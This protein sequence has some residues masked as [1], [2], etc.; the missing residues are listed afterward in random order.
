MQFFLH[1]TALFS[2]RAF[3][4]SAAR[5]WL[6]FFLILLAVGCKYFLF[7]H[8]AYVFGPYNFIK[9]EIYNLLGQKIETLANKQLPA[10]NHQ[11]VWYADK[12]PSGVY[13]YKLRAGDYSETKKMMLLK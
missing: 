13:F 6:A 7:C 8:R 1:L 5:A 12:Y 11:V 10:G 3:L 9:I 4:Q 2:G